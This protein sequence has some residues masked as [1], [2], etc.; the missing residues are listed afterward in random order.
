MPE[1]S[2]KRAFRCPACKAGIALTVEARVLSAT[3]LGAG[4]T[5]TCPL[6]Q[7][8]IA[9]EE[10]VVACPACDQIHHRECWAE[11]GGCG[12]YGCVQA[13]PLEKGASAPPV[14]LSAWGDE[15]DCPAC[16]EKIKAIALKCRYC[17]TAF[18]T[19]DPLTLADMRRRVHTSERASTLQK[20]VIALFVLSLPGC[21]APLTLVVGAIVLLPREAELKK[22]GPTF[23]VLGYSSLVLSTIYSVLILVFTIYKFMG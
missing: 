22:A 7:S 17:G 4:Q 10:A 9:A 14:P 12:T 3:R 15:K 16:G 20:S 8:A 6:C 21:L 18:D 13:V 5:A 2:G 11:V 19:V 1:N 23:V